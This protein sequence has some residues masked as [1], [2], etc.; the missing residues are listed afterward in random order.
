MPNKLISDLLFE[1]GTLLSDKSFK[2]W[3][4]QEGA[5][6]I[7]E[8]QVV[9]SR[10]HL[11]A[12][13]R[14]DSVKLQPGTSQRLLFN[15]GY[16]I[17]FNETEQNT[18]LTGIS[19]LNINCNMGADGRTPGEPIRVVSIRSQNLSNPGWR[20]SK[21]SRVLEYMSDPT[22]PSI[23]HVYP[24]VPLYPRSVW[25]QIEW[26]VLPENIQVKDYV[27]IDFTTTISL[28]DEYAPDILNYITARAHM[29]DATVA[30]AGKSNMF[31]SQFL[32]SV[33][34][35]VEALTGTNPNLKRLPFGVGIGESK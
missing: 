14:I 5:R 4:Q 10:L 24:G 15:A 17:R 6:W 30:D 21:G 9:L 18:P 32:A 27:N 2:H 11:S 12:S 31:A 16:V 7:N 29:K 19:L 1:W 25:V 23:F 13:V 3:T 22:N 35:K 26:N 33:N 34:S 8:A 20:T 28:P